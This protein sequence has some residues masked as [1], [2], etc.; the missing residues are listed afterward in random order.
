[1]NVG[2]RSDGRLDPERLQAERLAEILEARAVRRAVGPVEL[3]ADDA[4]GR[5]A[6]AAADRD[7]TRVVLHDEHHR[8]VVLDRHADLL[9]RHQEV[10]VTGD[11]G[12]LAFGRGEFRAE[13][14]GYRPAHRGEAARGQVGARFV[15]GEASA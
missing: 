9:G 8:D 15:D 1:M 2:S 3:G 5:V 14:G 7:V 6:L 10:A 12:D 13:G 4:V 11:A